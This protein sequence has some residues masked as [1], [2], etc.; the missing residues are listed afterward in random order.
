MIQH[1]K[2]LIWFRGIDDFLSCSPEIQVA[3]MYVQMTCW[4]QCLLKE[5]Y[6]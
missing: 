5:D 4:A 1:K 2:I 6:V 3:G